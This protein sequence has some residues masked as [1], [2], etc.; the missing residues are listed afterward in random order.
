MEERIKIIEKRLDNLEA[1]YKDINKLVIQIEKLATE[2]MYLREDQNKLTNRVENL[3]KKP[4]K[5]YDTIIT[6]IITGIV[7]ALVGAIMALI[8]KK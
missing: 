6:T 2:T 3:E 1:I 5:R 4:E 7:S 8:I